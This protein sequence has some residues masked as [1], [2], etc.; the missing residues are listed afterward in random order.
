MNNVTGI[1]RLKFLAYDRNHK[2]EATGDVTVTVKN[3]LEEAILNLRVRL[4]RKSTSFAMLSQSKPKQNLEMV[5]LELTEGKLW[6]LPVF[7][8]G[9][10]EL[11]I[12]PI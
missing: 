10:V 3:L 11:T 4:N 7:D 5:S 8:S 9:F 1:H 6:P 2:Q 12:I